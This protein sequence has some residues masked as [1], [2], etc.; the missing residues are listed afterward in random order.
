MKLILTCEHGGYQI[1]EPYAVLFEK[2]DKVL[3]SHRGWDPGALEL[4]QVLQQNL[5]APGYYSLISRLLVDLNRSSHHPKVFSEFV[6]PLKE[7]EKLQLLATYYAPHR[8]RIEATISQLGSAETVLH[9]A[10]HTFTPVLN[11]KKRNADIG[12]LY[13]PSREYESAF[14]EKWVKKLRELAPHLVVRKNYPYLGKSDGLPTYLRTRF[15]NYIGIEL[16]V[17]QKFPLGDANAWH[18]LQKIILRSLISS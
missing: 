1:P 15:S 10:I 4:F 6:K 9:I 5:R 11:G 14:A 12:I 2:A 13:D 16:E 8:R 18:E 17:N 7:F 3:K